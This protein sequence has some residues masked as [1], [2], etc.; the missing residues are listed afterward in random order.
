MLNSHKLVKEDYENHDEAW[1]IPAE[2]NT[3]K[4]IFTIEKEKIFANSWV[5]VSH[6]SEVANKH[7]YI[8]REI[9]GESIIIIRGEDDVL[10]GFYNVCPHRGHRLLSEV[11]GKKPIIF[12]PYHAWAFKPDGQLKYAPNSQNVRNFDPKLASLTPVNVTE[13]AGFVFI[14]LSKTPKSI[15]TEYA[16][17]EKKVYQECPVVDDLK[18]AARFIHNTAANWKVI[19]DNFI[20]CYHCPV[21][22]KSFA[23]SVNINVYEHLTHGNWTVQ[24]GKA[25]SSSSSY[26]FDD[27]IENPRWVGFWL[28]PCTMYT[29]P[30]GGGFMTALYEFPISADKTLQYYDMYFANE[31]LTKEQVKLIDWYEKV[32]RPEDIC[33]VE[34]VQQGLKSR[35]YSGRGRLMTD[36]QRSGL[37]EHAVAHF[38]E[39]IAAIHT[40]DE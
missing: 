15:E 38:H 35:G 9:I 22:H 34:S 26:D 20:E 14:N 17:L 3:S 23:K 6:K 2:Y 16:G 27:S 24:T 28:W 32:F 1:T 4:S 7:S 11:K 8:I 29:I 30:P 40:A 18:L 12:C 5:C 37:S 25:K 10:R 39:L 19:V 33:L 36:P 21:N 31:N 13:Y